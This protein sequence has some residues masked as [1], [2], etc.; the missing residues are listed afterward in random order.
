MS[1]V[2]GGVAWRGPEPPRSRDR[3]ITICI[4]VLVVD[5]VRRSGCFDR[6][7]SAAAD[8]R[9]MVASF[10]RPDLHVRSTVERKKADRRRFFTS[11]PMKFQQQS[12]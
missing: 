5:S 10:R 4:M 11:G 9:A 8:L 2:V 1:D 6:W 7:E 3:A 12:L